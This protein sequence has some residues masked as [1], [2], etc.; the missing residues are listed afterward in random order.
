MACPA[1]GLWHFGHTAMGA[2]EP[3]RHSGDQS[4]NL[5]AHSVRMAL[6]DPGLDWGGGSGSNGDDLAYDSAVPRDGDARAQS[7]DRG[8]HGKQQG[9]AVVYGGGSPVPRH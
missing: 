6:A 8:N 9:S 2:T 1:A 5:M 4:R 7:A 3:V